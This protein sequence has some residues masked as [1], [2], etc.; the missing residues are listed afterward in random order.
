MSHDATFEMFFEEAADLVRDCEAALLRLEQAI[1][2]RLDVPLG[3]A[4]AEDRGGDDRRSPVAGGDRTD[5]RRVGRVTTQIGVF[6]PIR[7]VIE[8]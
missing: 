6:E 8:L 5:D 2:I 1:K 7:L 4:R 3:T